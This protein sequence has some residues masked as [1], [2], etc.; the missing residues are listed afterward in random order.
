VKGIKGASVEE[1]GFLYRWRKVIAAICVLM[2]LGAFTATHIPNQSIPQEVHDLG[3]SVLHGVGFL[4]LSS[5]FILAVAGF[6]P[7]PIHRLLLV[8]SVMMVYA[9]LDEYTQQFFGRS[10]D[11]E[12]WITDTVATIVALALWES[13][14]WLHRVARRKRNMQDQ[15]EA[16]RPSR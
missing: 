11:L 15:R 16:A 2:W 13:V 9:A 7:K 12:D 3:G 8:L 6:W 1:R 5:W 4:G 10:T 14:F